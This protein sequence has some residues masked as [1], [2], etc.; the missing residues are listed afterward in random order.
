MEESKFSETQTGDDGLRRRRNSGV[1]LPFSTIGDHSSSPAKYEL[2]EA[3]AQPRRRGE[4][5]T[6][7]SGDETSPL[8]KSRPNS[9]FLSDSEFDRSDSW[10]SPRGE[11]NLVLDRFEFAT[12]GTCAKNPWS[13]KNPTQGKSSSDK[14]ASGAD[15]SHKKRRR[16]SRRGSKAFLEGELSDAEF[17]VDAEASSGGVW[18]SFGEA[19]PW[20]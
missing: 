12:I 9:G 20:S 4:S 10:T 7:V 19:T 8:L 6:D 11:M 1:S 13:S 2:P 14:D 16:K 17:G 5:D 15:K 18:A 3:L